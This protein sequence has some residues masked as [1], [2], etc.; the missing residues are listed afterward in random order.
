MDIDDL[1]DLVRQAQCGD[2]GRARDAW[3]ALFLRLVPELV[4]P[5]WPDTSTALVLGA[6]WER[7]W[8]GIRQF[9]GAETPK[10]T[11]DLLRGWL[12]QIVRTTK[13]NA[14]SR[15]PVRQRNAVPLA[16]S[17]DDSAVPDFTPQDGEASVLTCLGNQEELARLR[18]AVKNLPE[19]DQRRVDLVF[20]QGHSVRQAAKIFGCDESTFRHHL[21]RIFQCLRATMGGQASCTR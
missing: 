11:A 18:S 3:N 1:P 10:L 16:G 2:D 20:S 5:D 7:G 19:P 21:D 9:R 4:S 12:R 6:V 17:P 14:A 13:I 8:K 15:Q